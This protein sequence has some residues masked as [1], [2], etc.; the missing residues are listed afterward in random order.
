MKWSGV[1]G[2]GTN[3]VTAEHANNFPRAVEL[4][5][6]TLVEVLWRAQNMSVCV[7]QQELEPEAGCVRATRTKEKG[8]ERVVGRL[9]LLEFGLCLRHGE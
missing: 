2:W 5:K 4:D 1:G 7:A 8:R 6:Q 3:I 9:Y